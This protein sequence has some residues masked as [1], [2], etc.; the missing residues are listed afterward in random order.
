M[1]G[2]T[3]KRSCLLISSGTIRLVPGMSGVRAAGYEMNDLLH[4]Y[5]VHNPS[6][7]KL[8]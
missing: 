4:N 2:K 7:E 1:R 6:S 8:T 3:N 5:F